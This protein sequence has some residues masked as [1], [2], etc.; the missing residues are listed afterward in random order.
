LTT[1]ASHVED[2]HPASAS[3]ARGTHP[4]SAIHAWG[5]SPVTASHTGNRSTASASHVINPSLTFVS[6]V[7]DV[8]PTILYSCWGIDSVE[9]PIWIGCKPKFPCKI[10]KGDHLTHLC[11][12]ILEVQILWSLSASSSYSESSQVFSQPIQPLVAKVIMPMQSSIDPTP[13]LVSEVP[14]DLVVSQPMQ[15]LV[16][17]VVMPI[18]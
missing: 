8:Q 10:C 7:G 15:T 6:H 18:Q 2:Q 5:K 1:Y 16:E 11:P 17:K 13:L 3:Y 9:K 12:G 14:L 4:P